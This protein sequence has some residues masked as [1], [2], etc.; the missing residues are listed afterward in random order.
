MSP[1]LF[2]NGYNEKTDNWACGII[3]Y[4]LI[5]GLPP[6]IGNKI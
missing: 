1:E 6:F 2:G 4:Q 3:M 5:I